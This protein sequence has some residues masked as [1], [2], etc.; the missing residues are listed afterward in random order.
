MKLNQS[1]I[2]CVMSR[3]IRRCAHV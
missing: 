3:M 1:D 2:A